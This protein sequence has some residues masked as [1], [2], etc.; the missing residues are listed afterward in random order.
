MGIALSLLVVLLAGDALA[1]EEAEKKP[2]LRFVGQPLRIPFECQ[3]DDLQSFSQTCSVETPCPV[4]LQL[5]SIASAGP[6]IFLA[7]N[8]HNRHST[9]YSVLLASNDAGQT[10]TEPG[11]RIRG[12]G[13]DQL[14]FRG[15]E[16]GW[17]SGQMLTLPPRDP[18]FLLTT[19]GGQHWRR[20]NIFDDQRFSVIEEFWFDDE[21]SGGLIIDRVHPSET[22]ARYE[23]YETMTGGADWMIREVSPNP[24]QRRTKAAATPSTDWQLREDAKA[25]AWQVE[26][27]QGAGWNSVAAFAV[28]VGSCAPKEEEPPEAEAEEKKA[29]PEELPTA[30]G[31][32]F[33]LP[34]PRKSPKKEKPQ[35]PKKESQLAA[36]SR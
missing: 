9:M 34:G 32:V 18:F 29:V 21:K 31:G 8:L 14:Y 30:P 16:N 4:Y 26:Q 23:R 17:A 28:E 12:A 13:L 1:A 22:G 27:R 20:R 2:V 25:Q 7:G 15:A 6:R 35:A 19:D 11:E 5:S 33:Q 36:P 10:W 24:I 3:Q